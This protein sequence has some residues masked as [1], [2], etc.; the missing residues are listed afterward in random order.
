[1]Y[2]AGNQIVQHISYIPQIWVN[3]YVDGNYVHSSPKWMSV[4]V[5]SHEENIWNYTGTKAGYTF[6]GWYSSGN[7]GWNSTGYFQP[8]VHVSLTSW[9][10]SDLYIE[11][12]NM[13]LD[14]VWQKNAWSE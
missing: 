13:R 5:N 2:L 10:R 11:I 8:G 9:Q 6:R 4:Y 3:Y 1:M 14:A 12:S 7:N